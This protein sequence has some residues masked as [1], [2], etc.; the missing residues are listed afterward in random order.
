[1]SAGVMES[2]S[3][4]TVLYSDPSG[5]FPLVS[6]EIASRLPLRNLNWQSSPLRPLRQIRQ[7]HVEF[8]PD[9]LT[10]A[11][12]RPPVQRFDSNGPTSFEIVRSG[13]D[14]RRDAV[15][16]RR[17]QIPGFKTSPYLKIYVLRCDDKDVYK[18]TERKRIREW[19]RE[20]AQSEDK[21][22]NH[23]AFEWLILHVVIPDTVAA[24]EPRWRES[25]SEPDTLKERKRSNVKFPGKSTRTVF[26]RL[27]A[28]FNESG[29]TAQDR[30]AQIRLRKSDVP[31]DLLP[32]PAVAETL[33][34]TPQERENAWKDLMDKFKVLILGPFD[35]RVRQYE[36]DIAAQEA[37]RS[38]PGWNF[39]TF[40]IHKEGLAKALE[41]IGLVED[42]LVIYD[43][44]SL[45]LETV[46]RDIASGT[47]E[48]TATTFASYTDDIQSRITRSRKSAVNGTGVNGQEPAEAAG[49]FSKD[50]REQIV[51]SSISVF[52]F[53]CYLFSR[54]KA[55]ILRLANA[56]VARTELGGHTKDGGEDLV[57]TSEVCWRTSSFIHNTART[58]RRDLANRPDSP[59]QSDMEALV[60]SWSYA[61]AEQ[62]LAETAAP[63]LDLVESDDTPKKSLANGTFSPTR[64]DFSFGM[65]AN[66]YP[67]R[68]TSLGIQKSAPELHRPPSTAV[69]STMS[70]PSS[71]GTD[72]TAPKGAGIPG[73]PELATYRAE[74]IMIQRKMLEELAEARG[75]YV[76]WNSLRQSRLKMDEV[77]LESDEK[78]NDASADKEPAV[79][80]QLYSGVRTALQSE[81]AYTQA[82]EQMSDRAMRYYALATQ[83]KSVESIL[84]DLALLRWQEGDFAS[85]EE[86]I[87]HLLP[88]YETDAWSLMQAE[89]LL[90]HATCLKKLERLEQNISTAL[91]LL[92]KV[93]GK[94]MARKL[95]HMKLD[96]VDDEDVD[97]SGLFGEVLSDSS[98]LSRTI[99]RPAEQYFDQ[100]D[101]DRAVVH[102][103]AKDGF[104]LQLR[105]RHLLDDEITLDEVSARLISL[106][107]PNQEVWLRSSEPVTLKQG[108]NQVQLES[109]T[110]TFG[111]YLTDSVVFQAKQIRFVR[112]LRPRVEPAL[113]INDIELPESPSPPNRAALQHLVFL[114]P[115]QS[116]FDAQ[117]AITKDIRIDR[118]RFVEL[119]VRSGWNEIISLEIKLKPLSA[120]L[121][122]HLAESHFDG[123]ERQED[124][125]KS[126]GLRLGSLSAESSA[127]VKIPY[128]LEHNISEITV[129]IEVQ[130]TTPAGSFTFLGSATL[131]HELPFDVD[132]DDNFHLDTLYSNFTIHT[133]STGPLAI[134]ET[135]LAESPVY[136]VERPPLPDTTL[137]VFDKSPANFVYK[138]VRKADFGSVA[139]KDAALALSV[140]YVS[141]VELLAAAVRET[142]VARLEQSDFRSIGCLLLPILAERCKQLFTSADME[143]AVLLDQAKMPS[144]DDFGWHEIINALAKPIQSDL[145]AWL[146]G[147]HS[148]VSF[149]PINCTSELACAT[150]RHI[151]LAVDVPTIDMVFNASLAF[152]GRVEDSSKSQVD[153]IGKA[154]TAKVR[155]L[156]TDEWSAKSIFGRE[157]ASGE[158][159][160]FV[161]EVQAD[162]DTW[163]VG[164]SRR[165]HFS[166]KDE[167]E[168]EFDLIL[169]PL[170]VG[171]LP[172]PTIDV[173]P[174]HVMGADGAS[175]Q[176]VGGSVSC[177]THYQSGGQ[178]IQ[179]IR[180]VRTTE[181]SI[182]E[183]PDTVALPSSR[184]S[185]ASRVAT[186]PG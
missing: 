96:V 178:T 157:R 106:D 115:A 140:K 105:F 46:L 15:K 171:Q 43:E 158:N 11:T 70:P 154:I 51:R 47:A 173:Q 104:G 12:L 38:L 94:K 1:M 177:E 148:D 122:L 98:G 139:K 101:L 121:R 184:P 18:E 60:C 151:T 90:V 183:S 54:Q 30:V 74:L 61:V 110:I 2:S 55:M 127:V 57:L 24:S 93:C 116:S 9:S 29:K 179:V 180:N 145:T 113:R 37:R 123:I 36:A 99:S 42:A 4:V 161:C 83:T 31:P 45:G 50:Y 26:D 7:L 147:W 155:V 20:N 81:A 63:V 21:R 117:M 112:E 136:A 64:T 164:G 130:Y 182:I 102:L 19:I 80:S 23:D 166:P 3:K 79:S 89:L 108:L 170:K 149:L 103:D 133:T 49:L 138:I 68:S 135:D 126:A 144:F 109:P 14:V 27:R 129:R 10:Q 159:K 156:H 118:L 146:K 131:R 97:I 73:L 72:A 85:A 168:L 87:K 65:G 8:V 150:S 153:I 86:F 100:V 162:A 134:L 111:A 176:A 185:T 167:K 28:D 77:S 174:E 13:R 44:L 152:A 22:D 32:T 169:I 95:P 88:S 186:E 181:V 66:P 75:W 34:E 141:I 172:L 17:H 91:D 53:F 71:S 52:D 25:Q 120:G 16:E 142:F 114:Y 125:G 35:A 163:I 48:G 160:T 84:G 58:L 119:A 107:D 5:V 40:F 6:R 78:A 56:Q 124:S 67:Q 69:E 76:G 175:E 59:S 143:V 33:V 62:V 165:R 137:T 39:C 82:Y 41:S 128:S 132:V 92:A